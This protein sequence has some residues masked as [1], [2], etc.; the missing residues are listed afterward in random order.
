[1]VECGRLEICYRALALSGVQ[2]PLSPTDENPT[3]RVGLFFKNTVLTVPL[4]L[5][6]DA[7]HPVPFHAQNRE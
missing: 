3:E 5:C 1:M 2:I 7:L 4:M 6:R